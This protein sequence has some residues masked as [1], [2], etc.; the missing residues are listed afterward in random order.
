WVRSALPLWEG[1][2]T[3]PEDLASYKPLRVESD[4]RRATGVFSSGSFQM[5]ERHEQHT[6]LDHKKENAMSTTT[7]VQPRTFSWLTDGFRDLCRFSDRH[8]KIGI[9]LSLSRM[10][11]N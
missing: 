3:M 6:M 7:G 8:P 10:R 9:H 4:A 2:M 5:N 11:H 1:Q